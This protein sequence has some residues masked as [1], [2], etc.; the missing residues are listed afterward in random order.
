MNQD[1]NPALVIRNK[2]AGL[3]HID[4]VSRP[5]VLSIINL[6]KSLFVIKA[7][8]HAYVDGTAPGCYLADYPVSPAFEGLTWGVA[9][10]DDR[11]D[12]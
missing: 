4:L 6:N 7:R 12:Y 9:V 11:A 8:H 1:I 2:S 5:E 3:L 10:P